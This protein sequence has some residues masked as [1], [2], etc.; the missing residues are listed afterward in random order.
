MEIFKWDTL[1]VPMKLPFQNIH[2]SFKIERVIEFFDATY[3]KGQNQFPD[4]KVLLSE[5]IINTSGHIIYFLKPND[6]YTNTDIP[7]KY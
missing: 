6:L 7:F 3:L 5:N 2:T 1:T 4:T